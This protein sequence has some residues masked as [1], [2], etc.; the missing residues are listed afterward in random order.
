M[1]ALA[2]AASQHA[3]LR[4]RVQALEPDIDERTLSDTL[5]GLTNLHEIIGAVIRSALADEALAHS[6]K[7]RIAVMRER[8]DRL[9]RRASAQRDLVRDVMAGSE[10][11]KITAPEFTIS[12]R[13]GAPSLIVRDESAI[14]PRYWETR[15]P[16]LNRQ[17]LIS[18]L[19][20]GSQIAGCELSTPQA[21]LSVRVR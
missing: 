18:E 21:V 14:P 11:K 12:L 7:Q 19:K 4:E 5:E 10:I 16:H 15:D 3:Y 20:H 1:S 2:V 13:A 6:L 9:E 8:L 17:A